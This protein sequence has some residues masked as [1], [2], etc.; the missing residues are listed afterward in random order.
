MT[1]YMID[2]T[3]KNFKATTVQE[4]IAHA[5]YVALYV[6]GTPDIQATNAEI[7]QVPTSKTL[8]TIDQGANGSPVK[9][10]VVRDVET[11]A[12]LLENAVKT[13]GW[14][15]PGG[16]RCIYCTTASLSALKSFGWKEDV[17]VAAPSPNFHVPYTYEGLNIVAQQFLMD[18]GDGTYDVSE[19]F[20]E[21]WPRMTDKPISLSVTVNHRVADLA[22]EL[23][24]DAD[25]YVIAYGDTV[26]G[27]VPQPEVTTGSH[28][29]T[30]MEIPGSHSGSLTV[31][32]IVH[33]KA[34]SPAT[35]ELP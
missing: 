7:S 19:V 2:A 17:W 16:R 34:T 29:I 24:P 13:D 10:A 4:A 3:S 1:T 15:P 23:V 33:G 9:D 32:P 5:Q 20:D 25:H 21:T 27:R 18:Q 14:N 31:S 28:H 22:F 6:T 11:G 8:I 30:D 35:L 12:W 26:L